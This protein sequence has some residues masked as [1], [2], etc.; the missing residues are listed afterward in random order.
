MPRMWQKADANATATNLRVVAPANAARAIINDNSGSTSYISRESQVTVVRKT[1][2][3]NDLTTGG[4]NP[5]AAE[6]GKNLAAEDA[7]LHSDI[8]DVNAR[9]DAVNVRFDGSTRNYKTGKC[10]GTS[11]NLL[12]STNGAYFDNYIPIEPGDI[13]IW[14]SGCN[15][16]VS[17]FNDYSIV[18]YDAEK[19]YVSRTAAN[20]LAEKTVTIASGST[21]R[22]IRACFNVNVISECFIKVNG[23]TVWTP[24]EDVKGIEERIEDLETGGGSV[25]RTTMFDFSNPQITD[26]S[27]IVSGIYQSATSKKY[28]IM[29]TVYDKFDALVAA[30][31]NVITKQDAGTLVGLTYPSYANLDGAD[32]QYGIATPTY[33]TYIYTISIGAS[34]NLGTK[35][36]LLLFGATHGFESMGP[37]DL[38]ALATRLCTAADVNMIKMLMYFDIYIVPCF[39]GF[40]I[41]NA[42]RG[43][44]NGVDL[45]RN[46][47]TSDWTQTESS[48]V[49]YSG[50]SAGSEF[51]TQLAMGLVDLLKPDFVLD[52]HSYDDV[53]NYNFY[54]KVPSIMVEASKAAKADLAMVLMRDYPQ[55]YGTLNGAF[56]RGILKRPVSP[57]QESTPGSLRGWVTEQ[58]LTG[59][60][61]ECAGLI[62][63]NNGAFDAQVSTY[64]SADAEN[65]AFFTLE[66]QLLRYVEC[67]L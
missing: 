39:N 46:F 3:V 5:L 32:S 4:T 9:V 51:E 40:G 63:Y 54:T 26:V 8:G 38:T 29:Q 55:Y 37:I 35:K 31:P 65:I 23:S 53:N 11:G 19:N 10:Y 25:S 57:S 17:S 2:V 18:L 36:K 48:S 64:F 47:P 20:Y 49:Y 34:A 41:I 60:L 6:Q 56:G 58:G 33:R 7:Q 14:H 43:N 52:H 30:Y 61:I 15:N 66:H 27:A 44:G 1:D 13:I 42:K 21:A 50:P 62:N 59:I 67:L 28:L 16:S 12:T 24:A 45:N 22:F